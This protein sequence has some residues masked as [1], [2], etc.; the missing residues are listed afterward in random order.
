LLRRRPPGAR[1][2]ALLGEPVNALLEYVSTR[3]ELAHAAEILAS[4]EIAPD[5]R[6]GEA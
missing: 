3:P 2:V 1:R 4:K 5:E 6:D